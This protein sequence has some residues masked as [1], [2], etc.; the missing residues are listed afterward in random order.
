[1]SRVDL[2]KVLFQHM[3]STRPT[4]KEVTRC[5]LHVMSSEGVMSLEGD[6]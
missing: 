3:F 2:D 4:L 5:T 1:V 6:G